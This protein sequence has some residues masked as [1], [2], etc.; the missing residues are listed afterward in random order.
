MLKCTAIATNKLNFYPQYLLFTHA[1][2]RDGI[3]GRTPS[4]GKKPL[5]SGGGGGCEGF[6]VCPALTE[7]E[8]LKGKGKNTGIDVVKGNGEKKQKGIGKE[9]E[10]RRRRL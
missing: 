4:P 8:W 10:R 1:H 9:M 3:S 2:R 6:F 5:C 7:R